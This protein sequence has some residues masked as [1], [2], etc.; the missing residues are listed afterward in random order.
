[1]PRETS[2]V[3]AASKVNGTWS[4]HVPWIKV[5]GKDQVYSVLRFSCDSSVSLRNNTVEPRHTS[6]TPSTGSGMDVKTT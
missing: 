1:M 6:T 2:K 4:D 5:S 3:P